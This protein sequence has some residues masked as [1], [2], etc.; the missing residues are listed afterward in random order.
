MHTCDNFYR[1][2]EKENNVF[3]IVI[4]RKFYSYYIN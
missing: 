3:I 4:F 1:L 2:K